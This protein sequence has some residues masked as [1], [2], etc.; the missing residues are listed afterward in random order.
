MLGR[1]H[2]KGQ[3]HNQKTILSN[4]ITGLSQ[5]IYWIEIQDLKT[6]NRSGKKF[7]KQ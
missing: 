7:I 4:E 1:A 3:I 5:G 2:W 6:G